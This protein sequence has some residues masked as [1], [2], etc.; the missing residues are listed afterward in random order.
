MYEVRLTT[1]HHATAG[2]KG[3]GKY[4]AYMEEKWLS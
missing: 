3:I 4:V 1:A 2:K